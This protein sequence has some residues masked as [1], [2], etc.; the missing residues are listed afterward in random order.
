MIEILQSDRAF[1]DSPHVGASDC[2]C[3]RCEKVIK[4]GEGA[5]RGWTGDRAL[6]YRYHYRCLGIEK[7]T[8][9]WY[10]DLP[11]EY[12]Q[13]YEY[14]ELGGISLG[15][16]CACRSSENVVNI[17]NLPYRT[18]IPRTGWGNVATGLPTDGA[19]AVICDNCIQNNFDIKNLKDVV[20]GYAS[21]K[22]RK[23]FLEVI[24]NGEF[25]IE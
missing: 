1:P 3:S 5:I 4:E 16:C 24:K 12:D 17:I 21:E 2:F 23:P 22:Q 25:L 8:D 18:F 6:E 10:D 19:I 7:S 15:S 11:E 20:Y 9:D 13:T 14:P